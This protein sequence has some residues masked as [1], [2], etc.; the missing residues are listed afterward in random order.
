LCDVIS[1]HLFRPPKSAH[2]HSIVISF[3]AG[4]SL[5]YCPHIFHTTLLAGLSELPV[6]LVCIVARVSLVDV[7][8]M[9]TQ[10]PPPIFNSSL[11]G[12]AHA[13]HVYVV[14]GFVM[15]V[16]EGHIE[17]RQWSVHFTSPQ[18]WPLAVAA[19]TALATAPPCEHIPEGRPVT[20]SREYLAAAR[21]TPGL[22]FEF[23]VLCVSWTFITRRFTLLIH[24]F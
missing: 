21:H 17:P 5:P 9:H 4:N 23:Q 24:S 15:L 6:R 10:A 18:E 8:R 1:L 22:D 11:D 19:V 3:V 20:S 14:H 7:L 2:S 13:A 12:V 16:Y